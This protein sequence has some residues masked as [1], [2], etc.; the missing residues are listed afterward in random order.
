MRRRIRF[1]KTLDSRV[2]GDTFAD[3][4]ELG[5]VDDKDNETTNGVFVYVYTNN[6]PDRVFLAYLDEFEYVPDLDIVPSPLGYIAFRNIVKDTDNNILAN[7]GDTGTVIPDQKQ[8][9]E[10]HE[11]WIVRNDTCF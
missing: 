4:G 7:I 10:R 11:Y 5:Y 1:T 2:F 3:K 6:N 9:R 8:N